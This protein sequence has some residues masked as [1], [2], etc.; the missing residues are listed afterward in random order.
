MAKLEFYGSLYMTKDGPIL[1]Q[2][3][4]LGL[5]VNAAKKFREGDLAKIGVICEQPLQLEYDGPKDADGLWADEQFRSSELVKLKGGRILRTRP[6]F[7]EWAASV[8][9]AIDTRTVNPD[10]VTEWLTVGGRQVCVG[11]WRPQHGR[12][13]VEEK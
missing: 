6:I 1:P 7:S 13:R 12:F 5:L 8:S 2:N 4:I 10:R 9:L 11:D 3:M